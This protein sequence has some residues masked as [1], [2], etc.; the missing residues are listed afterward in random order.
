MIRLEFLLEEPSMANVLK[1]ILPKILPPGYRLNENY[2]LRPHRGKS[3]LQKS[4]PNKIRT[5]SN[6]HEPVKIVILHDQDT[7]DCKKLKR[8]LMRLCEESGNCPVLIRII[9]RE[10][11]SWFLGDM[12]AMESAYPGFKA[13]KYK[14]KA[15]FRNPDKCQAFEELTAILPEFQKGSGSRS[16]APHLNFQQNASPSFQTFISGLKKF[17][18]NQC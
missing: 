1:V 7:N 10:L 5:F 9:C 3:D 2:F 12:D 8:Q 18:T 17:V 4:I 14:N 6:F 11:E 13:H 15:K 16:I